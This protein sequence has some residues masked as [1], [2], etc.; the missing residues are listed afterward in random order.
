MALLYPI[1]SIVSNHSH[2]QFASYVSLLLENEVFPTQQREKKDSHPTA[3]SH[4]SFT[5]SLSRVSASTTDFSLSLY[6]R[7]R[8]LAIALSFSLNHLVFGF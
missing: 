1:L 4:S 2:D 6:V 3:L 7:F 5:L 8:G